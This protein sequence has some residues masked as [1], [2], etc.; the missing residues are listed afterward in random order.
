MERVYLDWN[1][2]EPLSKAASEAMIQ[3]FVN[4]GNPSSI[5]FEGREA[6]SALESARDRIAE[7]VGLPSRNLVVFTSG[8][9]EGASMILHSRA[10]KC[11][12]IE[13]DCV[14]IWAKEN[15]P[16]SQNGFVE[17][18]EPQNS[19]LQIANS[20]TGI[21]QYIPDNIFFTDAVQAFG[22]IPI[23]FSELSYEFA[24][25]SSHKIG[26]PKG[27]G[28]LFISDPA[29]IEPII[30]GGGQETGL[31]SGTENLANILGFAS[32]VEHRLGEMKAGAQFE[33]SKKR[34]YLE[35][36]VKDVS[37]E[38]IIVGEE[39]NRLPNTSYL[40]TPGWKGY[41]Q[42]AGLDL[43]GFSVSSGMACASGKTGIGRGLIS[44]GYTK[45]SSECGI[46]VS[47]GLSTSNTDLEKFVD[48]WSSQV[49]NWKS[50]AA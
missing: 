29:A 46:R 31:R 15:L 17:V 2:S 44:M 32:A 5:H 3:S 38:T 30:K 11:A 19:S 23:D 43:E 47:I 41:E 37:K 34:N 12:P 20:E 21:I 50:Q 42:V 4:Y 26:G 14:H 24:I 27:I 22:K 16:V 49:K 6:R 45:E 35:S 18:K 36:M 39:V 25:I 13:H 28:A 40:L 9:T 8:A 7:L 1:A 48:V 10:F 33:I